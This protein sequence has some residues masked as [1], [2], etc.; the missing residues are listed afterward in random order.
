MSTTTTYDVRR[1][2]VKDAD[3]GDILI[4]STG[5]AWVILKIKHGFRQDQLTLEPCVSSAPAKR[6][7]KYPSFC[8]RDSRGNIGQISQN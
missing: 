1:G 7:Y 6:A 2:S 3:V 8:I 5:K 4:D